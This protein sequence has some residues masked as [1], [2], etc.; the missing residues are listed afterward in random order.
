MLTDNLTIGSETYNLTGRDLTKSLRAR[1]G[2]A[3]GI[4]QVLTISH[5]LATIAGIKNARHLARL[6]YYT[7]SEAGIVT[8]ASAYLVVN[9]PQSSVVTEAII[10]GMV[11][12]LAV[13][14]TASTNAD[15]VKILNNET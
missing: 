9:Q 13:L 5:S 14:V 6:D 4:D 7:A 2:D 1:T 8:T 10:K 12:Q 15:L 11:G 3:A